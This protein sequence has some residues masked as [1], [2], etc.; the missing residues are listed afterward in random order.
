MFVACRMASTAAP[1]TLCAR[2]GAV[3]IDDMQPL[4]A[5]LLEGP[6]LRGG[7]VVVDGRLLHVAE[8]QADALAVLEVDGGKRITGFHLRKLAMRARP[9]AWLFSGWNCVPAILSRPTIAV[10]GPP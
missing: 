10:T 6:R 4:E 8:L 1:L 2:E 9:S 3:E 5:L 7:V